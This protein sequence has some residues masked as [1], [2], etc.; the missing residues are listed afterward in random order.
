MVCIRTSSLGHIR[1]SRVLPPSLMSSFCTIKAQPWTRLKENRS[2]C[3]SSIC[4]RCSNWNAAKLESAGIPQ[5]CRVDQLTG[6]MAELSSSSSVMTSRRRGNPPTLGSL[7]Q[8]HG[9][10]HDFVDTRTS[11]EATWATTMTIGSRGAYP[12]EAQS[13]SD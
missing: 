5:R 7:P 12:G 10:C 9:E 8:L 4:Y 6:R 13:P 3:L 2:E 11:L 1:R